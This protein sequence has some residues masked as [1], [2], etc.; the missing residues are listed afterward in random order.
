MRRHLCFI[1]EYNCIR[2]HESGISRSPQVGST[3][4][5]L[6]YD[7]V[8]RILFGSVGS[9]LSLDKWRTFSK[10]FASK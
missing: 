10:G 2:Y 5:S 9:E 7:R 1:E 6:P 3:I 8:K 4:K